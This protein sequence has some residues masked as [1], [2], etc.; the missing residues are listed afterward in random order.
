M[1]PLDTIKQVIDAA[2]VKASLGLKLTGWNH[3]KR[4]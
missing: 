4:R 1:S 3:G 2:C